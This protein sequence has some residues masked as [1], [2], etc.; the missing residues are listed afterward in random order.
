MKRLQQVAEVAHEPELVGKESGKIVIIIVKNIRCLP[1]LSRAHPF[2]SPSG[3]K[4]IVHRHICLLD[5]F[6]E[7]TLIKC[8]DSPIFTAVSIQNDRFSPT[9]TLCQLVVHADGT[10][11]LLACK[12]PVA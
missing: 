5:N 2:A 6:T 1:L 10:L 3:S 12:A 8:H 7:T 9:C 4:H 11:N